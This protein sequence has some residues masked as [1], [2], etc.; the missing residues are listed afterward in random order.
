MA[1]EL[2]ELPYERDAFTPNF[3]SETFDYH[4]GKHHNAYV[5]NLNNL[6]KDNKE[7]TE[8]DL[9]QIIAKSCSSNAAIFNNASQIWNHTFFW[10]SIK[11]NGGG[12]PHGN[13]AEL[14][15]A[16]FGSYDNFVTE[17]KQAA[18]SQFGSG[19]AWLCVSK[20]KL[21]ISSTANQDNPLMDIEGITYGTPIL[22]LDVWEHA[23]YLNYQ[24][25]RP[26]YISSFFAI[27]NWNE[28]SNRFTA[29]L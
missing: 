24:N 16:N 26:D 28:V 20:G 27:I 1:F 12:K 7:F 21:F 19:W 2:P 29:A 11:P 22:G 14:I 4:H 13:I 17:F 15:N 18:V 8:M 9:E 3:S 6:L 5:T 25:R 23:Y 10:H